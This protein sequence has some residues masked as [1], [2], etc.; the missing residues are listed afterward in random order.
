MELIWGIFLRFL[1]VRVED[2]ENL[3][4]FFFMK[5]SVSEDFRRKDLTF[6]FH[7]DLEFILAEWNLN[8][9]GFLKFCIFFK[10]LCPV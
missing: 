4:K 9:T 6:F 10:V 7:L 8:S 2:L 3:L 5:N 1:V